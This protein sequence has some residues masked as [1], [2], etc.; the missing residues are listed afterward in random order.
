MTT[1][2]SAAEPSL[3]LTVCPYPGPAVPGGP[4]ALL[5]LHGPEFSSD[6]QATYR[7]L[8]RIGPIAPVEI[9]NGVTGY[10]TTTYAAA[11]HLLRNTPRRFSKDPHNWRAL[12]AGQVPA[13]SPA[14]GMMQARDNALWMDGAPHTRLRK[15]ITDSLALV[16]THSLAATVTSV[17]DSLIDAFAAKGACD[18]VA[19]FADPLPMHVLIEMFGSPPDTGRRIVRAIARLFDTA[20][21]PEQTNLEVDAACRELTQL[22][23][24]DPAPDVTSWLVGHEADLTDDEMSQQIL[25]IVGAG[26][27]P[28]TNLISNSLRLL[29]DDERFSGSVFEGVHSVGDVMDEVLWE[30][31]PVSNYSPLYARGP[32]T[33]EGVTLEP[34]VPILVSFAAAN[35]DPAMASSTHG[36]AGNRAHLAFSAGAHGCPAP[37]L[38]RVIVETAVERVLDRLPDME[39]ACPAGQLVR[40]PGTFHSGYASLPVVFPPNAHSATH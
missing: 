2:G 14:L 10:V 20:A 3:P 36:R 22:K 34:G 39:L 32:E 27:T 17:A 26:T 29:I 40:R 23:R 21:D 5:P 35:S 6:P 11:L 9:D 4:D 8:R 12:A 13:D 7:R 19:D 15:S 28:C 1:P 25:L 16:N 18:L 37:D 31:P 33:Y 30:D 24:K 38:A